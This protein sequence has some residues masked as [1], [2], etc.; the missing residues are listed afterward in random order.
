LRLAGF[1]EL[2][3][4]EVA[5][6]VHGVTSAVRW[7]GWRL[8][9]SGCAL[10]NLIETGSDAGGIYTRNMTLLCVNCEEPQC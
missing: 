2:H 3:A 5:P 10:W 6:Y 9:R 7:L 8:I 1:K 4:R